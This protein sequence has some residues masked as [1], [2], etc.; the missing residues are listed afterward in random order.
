M[1]VLLLG[2]TGQVGWE[3]Q[4]ALA[5]I[6]DVVALGR[7]AEDGLGGDLTRLDSLADA[8]RAIG[9]DVIVN[10][11]AY[12]QV[13]KAESEP[14]LARL[15]NAE[16]PAVLAGE[17]KKLGACL[18]H[19]STDY[20]FDGSGVRPWTEDDE[21]GPLSTYGTTKLAGEK[22]IRESGC[23]HLILRTSW[24]CFARHEFHQD[25][26]ASWA[27][28]RDIEYRRRSGWRADRRGIDRGRDIPYPGALKGEP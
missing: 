18:V 14:E 5:P 12:T 17:A 26:A 25:H 1:K 16:A 28:T 2:P 6:G 20:V 15:V 7:T 11:A 21:T 10:A 8:V 23:P 27:R 13:D 22:A 4:R 3:L 24:V 9:P 19:Y